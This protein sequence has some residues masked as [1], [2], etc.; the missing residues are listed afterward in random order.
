MGRRKRKSIKEV[1]PADVLPTY[2]ENDNGAKAVEGELSSPV[3]AI[4]E[5]F[6]VAIQIGGEEVATRSDQTSTDYY[7]DSYVYFSEHEFTDLSLFFVVTISIFIHKMS[8]K[9]TQTP[10]HKPKANPYKT[11]VNVHMHTL[12]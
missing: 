1:S 6:I 5:P 11:E 7:F 2:I 9:Y 10:L 8:C 3:I 12:K 4:T